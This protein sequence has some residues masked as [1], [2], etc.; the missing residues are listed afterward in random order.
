MQY[1][2]KNF[3]SNTID[4]NLDENYCGIIGL[5]PSKGAR[6]PK[7]WNH[8]FNKQNINYQFLPFDIKPKNLKKFFHFFKRS[9]NIKS[10]SITNPNK[11]K[12]LDF[13]DCV[14]I[15]K[16]G[17]KSINL[18]KNKNHKLIGYNTDIEGFKAAL[19]KKELK[20]KNIVIY[21]A[22]GGVGKTLLFDLLGQKNKIYA[23]NRSFSKIK[24][25]NK[26]RLKILKRVEEI[27]DL[28]N[29]DV[30]INCSS[31]KV[32]EYSQKLKNIINFIKPKTIYDINYNYKKSEILKIKRLLKSKFIIGKKMNLYQA[33]FAINSIFIKYSK[34]KIEKILLS[35]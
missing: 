18:I 20:K 34:K 35:I 1:N 5:N 6:S 4:Y 23:F 26:N 11:S 31:I 14:N 32:S 13:I 25:L 2:L 30:Y 33:I 19:D 16:K 7:I 15:K 29:V 12:A 28:S 21:G 22:G 8:F 24:R 27:K 3:I 9:K 10:I 17:I